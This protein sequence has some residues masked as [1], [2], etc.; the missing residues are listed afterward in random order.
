MLGETEGRRRRGQQRMRWLDGITNK[1]DKSLS[2]LQELVTDRKAWHAAVHGV[3]ESRTR[4]S[5]WTEQINVVLLT[6]HRKQDVTPLT[7]GQKDKV[8]FTKKPTTSDEHI[9]TRKHFH[10]NGDARSTSPTA[11]TRPAHTCPPAEKPLQ[12]W[13]PCPPHPPRAH[14]KA[15]WPTWP[16]RNEGLRG[17][18]TRASSGQLP[19]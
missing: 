8:Y 10:L 14:V 16:T 1:M 13:P 5:D 3:A 15:G 2:N 9:L 17:R 12:T 7:K 18:C 11:R 19:L 6:Q 4:L